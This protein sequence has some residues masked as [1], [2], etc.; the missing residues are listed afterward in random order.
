MR[1]CVNCNST[2]N[3]IIVTLCDSHSSSVDAIADDSHHVISAFDIKM[4]STLC[5][6][7]NAV[8]LPNIRSL[9]NATRFSR[10]NLECARRAARFA[11]HDPASADADDRSI[12]PRTR[13]SSYTQVERVS[14]AAT[15][16]IEERQRVLK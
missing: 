9:H 16:D 5:R 15:P 6:S 8:P 11:P 13:K 4:Q 7:V 3:P 12:A 10:Q 1:N 14:G 2:T